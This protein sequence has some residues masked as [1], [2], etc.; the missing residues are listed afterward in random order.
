MLRERE[1]H[2]KGLYTFREALNYVEYFHEYLEDSYAYVIQKVKDRYN[3]PNISL[4][5]DKSGSVFNVAIHIRRGDVLRV[6]NKFVPNKYFLHLI[7]QLNTMF[8]DK[9]KVHY[10]IFSDGKKGEFPEFQNNNNVFLHLDDEIPAALTLHH[11]IKSDLLIM[12]KSKYSFY[13]G[14]IT[15]GIVIYTPFFMS[16]PKCFEKDW[17]KVLDETVGLSEEQLESLESVCEKIRI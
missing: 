13:A 8:S 11:L 1:Y 9:L 17:V 3:P 10:H 15:E 16:I 4:M 2:Y 5:Y 12:S 6:P 14:L 7:T